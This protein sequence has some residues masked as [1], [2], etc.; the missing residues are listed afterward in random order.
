MSKIN[1][2]V[3]CDAID[4]PGI[5]H[6]GEYMEIHMNLSDDKFVGVKRVPG[7]GRFKLIIGDVGPSPCLQPGRYVFLDEQEMIQ[8]M[9]MLKIVGPKVED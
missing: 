8:L 9:E 7:A 3:R 1:I 2:R 4:A 6:G 5:V